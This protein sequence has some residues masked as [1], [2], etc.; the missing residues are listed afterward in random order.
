[1]ARLDEL[2]EKRWWTVR[3][4]LEFRV[5]A[6]DEEEAKRL[7]EE[8]LDDLLG[9]KCATAVLTECETEVQAGVSVRGWIEGVGE[10]R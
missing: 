2:L 10:K 1:M 3:Y 6:R 4:V 8:W 7:A 5:P 9:K